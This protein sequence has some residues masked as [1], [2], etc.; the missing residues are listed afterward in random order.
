MPGELFEL[1]SLPLM[2]RQPVQQKG[3]P[4]P[5]NC[6][7]QNSA[8]HIGTKADIARDSFPARKFCWSLFVTVVGQFELRK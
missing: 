2:P 5:E 4:A 1:L 8:D 6:T 3:E 7:K